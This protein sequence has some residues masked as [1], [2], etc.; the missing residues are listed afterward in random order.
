MN[1][2]KSCANGCDAPVQAPSKVLCKKCLDE[3]SE[4]FKQ[5]AE[6]YAE[7]ATVQG[8]AQQ[9]GSIQYD[10]MDDHYYYDENE[11]RNNDAQ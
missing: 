8:Q 11:E 4:K 2:L 10:K 1:P 5:L 6:R 7:K 3:L 9:K